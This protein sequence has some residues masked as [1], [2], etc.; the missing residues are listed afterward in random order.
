MT[1]PQ[2]QIPDKAD[3]IIEYNPAAIISLDPDLN[4]KKA[5]RAF[6]QLS[7]YTTETLKTMNTRSFHV[8]HRQG[9]S[10]LELIEKKQVVFGDII[11]EFPSG[12]RYMQYQYLPI[13]EP[14]GD[15]TEINAVFIDKTSEMLDKER[16]NII[17]EKNPGGICIFN[18]ELK[19]TQVNEAFL[20][21][22]GYNREDIIGRQITI[23][24][25]IERKGAGPT[26]AIE[27]KERVTTE[28]VVSFPVGRRYLT[29]SYTPIIDEHG[30]VT[31]VIEFFIDCTKE[32][33]TARDILIVA[34]KARHGIFSDRIN[35]KYYEGDYA[36]IA[37]EINS[38]LDYI[39]APLGEIVRVSD[40]YASGNFN[41]RFSEEIGVKG[42]FLQVRDAL[43]NIGVCIDSSLEELV[44]ACDAYEQ[45]DFTYQPG[46]ITATG[47]SFTKI[48][49]SLL[50]MGKSM[51]SALHLISEQT[52][53]LEKT[54]QDTS[55]TIIHVSEGASQVA[56]S[57]DEVKHNT[58]RCQLGIQQILSAMEDLSVAVDG[59]AQ[60][61]EKAAIFTSE[62]N[63][64][65][66]KG[67]DLTRT[68]EAGI[69]GITLSTG[70]V[71]AMIQEIKNQM[72]KI[73]K[74]VLLITEISNQ[75]NL[76]ALNAAIEAARAGDAGRGLR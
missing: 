63:H 9:G 75:T 19:I 56:A 64:L 7:G 15:I 30:T 24:D 53:I 48:Q 26:D 65:C 1:Q 66:K 4:I 37:T 41:T 43:D 60:K 73:D 3:Y 25:V 39:A 72:A 44:K 54:T 13:L 46:N 36:D 62:T 33:E 23:F 57:A 32:K 67:E 11:V 17:I 12:R 28:F 42:S 38:M 31:E 45:G 35:C 52:M 49:Q 59:V 6:I 34:E 55:E 70:E 8:L 14:E 47:S 5:N 76:L 69:E 20:L 61:V 27:R 2:Y 22:S 51:G 21:M 71:D 18:R 10:F 40:K 29:G 50:Q 58:E 74:I 16:A 68:A